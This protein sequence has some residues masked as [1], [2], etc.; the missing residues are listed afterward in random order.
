VTRA[1]SDRDE[2]EV[3]FETGPGTSAAIKVSRRGS[4]SF[5]CHLTSRGGGSLCGKVAVCVYV[6]RSLLTKW[7]SLMA[8]PCAL[9]SSCGG[10]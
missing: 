1:I 9:G 6:C 8:G 5:V 4:R 7:C 10:L 3:G 2:E